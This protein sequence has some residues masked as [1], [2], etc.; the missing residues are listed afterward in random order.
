VRVPRT[1]TVL[2]NGQRPTSVLVVSRGAVEVLLPRRHGPTVLVGRVGVGGIIGDMWVA[3]STTAPVDAVARASVVVESVPVRAFLEAVQRSPGR[4]SRWLRSVGVRL[5]A[6]QR[7]LLLLSTSDLSGQLATVLLEA[8][9]QVRH[10]RLPV[11]HD[12]LARLLGVRRPS[13]SRALARL[14]AEG[15][16]ETGYGTIAIRDGTRL[17]QLAGTA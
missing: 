1:T 13:V 11:S 7:R 16:V 3:T 12:D 9:Q 6:I 8:Q 14:R 2:R 17:E 10:D 5:D 15:L 4:L